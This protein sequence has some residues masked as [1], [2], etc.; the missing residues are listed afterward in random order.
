M[1][2]R[3]VLESTAG[4]H[5]RS[6]LTATDDI[7]GRLIVLKRL[8]DIVEL[9]ALRDSQLSERAICNSRQVLLVYEPAALGLCSTDT[10]RAMSAAFLAKS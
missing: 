7:L 4:K 1:T 8:S 10:P 2:H 9:V 3:T 5:L 6:G